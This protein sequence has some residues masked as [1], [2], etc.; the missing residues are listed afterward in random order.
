MLWG[1][2]LFMDILADWLRL[3]NQLDIMSSSNYLYPLYL[4]MPLIYTQACFVLTPE[5]HHHDTKQYFQARRRSFFIL[6]GAGLLLNL[7][8]GFYIYSD[9]RT[10]MRLI[11]IPFLAY[12]IFR[13]SIIARSILAALV[14]INMIVIFSLNLF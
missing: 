11:L 5:L 4:I 9:D 10:W 6:I 1:F 3:Y 7:I 14:I 8:G 13:D 12:N 2:L